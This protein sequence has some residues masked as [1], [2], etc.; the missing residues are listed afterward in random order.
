MSLRAQRCKYDELREA[1]C[2]T[3]GTMYDTNMKSYMRH[4]MSYG[5]R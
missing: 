2:V 4:N 1:K 3:G 5:A